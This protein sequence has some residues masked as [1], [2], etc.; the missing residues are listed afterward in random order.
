MWQ[1][2][3]EAIGRS[4]LVSD[5]RFASGALRRQNAAPLI[6]AIDAWTRRHTKAEAMRLLAEAGV[7]A[8]AVLD[9]LDLHQDPH[10]VERG[11]V[12]TVEHES[13]GAV[14][15]LGWPPRLSASEVE[16]AA[17]PLLGRHTAE[18]LAAE[19]GIGEAEVAALRQRGVIG[20]EGTGERRAV[21]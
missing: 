14:R 19:L 21:E 12:K 15:L 11:F 20:S 10:L 7:P 5:P 3:C 13:M 2:V 9:T 16:L 8:S 17:A 6:E 4:E 18:V 1:G